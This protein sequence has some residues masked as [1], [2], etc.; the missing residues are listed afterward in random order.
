MDNPSWAPHSHARLGGSAAECPT[1]LAADLPAGRLP[2]NLTSSATPPAHLRGSLSTAGLD[3]PQPDRPTNQGGHP[4]P[5]PG[6]PL[7]FE[8]PPATNP[9]LRQERPPP[10][11][12]RNAAR[13]SLRAARPFESRH[14][15]R[16]GSQS[17]CD[18]SQ[19]KPRH[20][21]VWRLQGW[22]NGSEGH[23]WQLAYRFVRESRR[24]WYPQPP[25]DPTAAHPVGAF[26]IENPS[27]TNARLLI[28]VLHDNLI[29]NLTNQ[30]PLA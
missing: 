25:N 15:R 4:S 8:P 23:K 27:A 11:R 29:T 20:A 18:A 17:S 10:K 26:P 22:S 6:S 14:R 19:C 2:A 3:H 5:V 24:K 7:D 28:T 16:Y 30:A 9:Q 21:L 13:G 12:N 1:N